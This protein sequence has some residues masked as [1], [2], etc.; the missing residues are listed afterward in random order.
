M[1]V[2]KGVCV[3]VFVCLLDGGCYLCFLFIPI[4]NVCIFNHNFIPSLSYLCVKSVWENPI[5]E[6][7]C[8]WL[9]MSITPSCSP[10]PPTPWMMTL[11]G[12]AAS[13]T[14]PLRDSVRPVPWFLGS[15]LKHRL[16][17][18]PTKDGL[19][20]FLITVDI[21]WYKCI[22]QAN[23][24]FSLKSRDGIPMAQGLIS[25]PEG[26]KCC[27][28]GH[29]SPPEAAFQWMELIWLTWYCCDLYVL[30]NLYDLF[31]V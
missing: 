27:A 30:E 29:L 24:R 22:Y 20:S 9:P 19:V 18:F 31:T 3:C 14:L 1:C 2:Y 5:L 16:L 12:T 28:Q 25:M 21:L 6:Y 17:H 26:I 4:V 11:L 10:Q 15:V 13:Y 8:L 7:D 23:R